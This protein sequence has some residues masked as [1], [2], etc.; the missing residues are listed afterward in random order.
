MSTAY[1]QRQAGVLPPDTLQN[2]KIG[3]AGVG[4][5]GRQVVL[6][7]V[8]AGARNLHFWDHDTVEE[9]NIGPQGWSPDDIGQPKVGALFS[10]AVSR[11]PDAGSI[12]AYESRF[13]AANPPQLD[14]FFCC[15]DK[16]ETR[17]SIFQGFS[18]NKLLPYFFD[19]R[20]TSDTVHILACCE[21]EHGDY[22]AGTIFEA[23]EAFQATC[24]TRMSIHMANI[25]AGLLIQQLSKALRE[26]PL[27]R[28]TVFN[29]LSM[30]CWSK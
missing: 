4:A 1:Y 21:N 5:V 24:T 18:E 17:G 13:P 25:A 10:D 16:I 20:V 23:E 19:S 27:D 6:Q 22:Y 11:F 15:V 28:H 30:E 29:L 14:V 9:A 26:M 12:T 7:L 8:S 3:V 2:L